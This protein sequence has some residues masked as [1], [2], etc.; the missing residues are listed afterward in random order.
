MRIGAV[1]AL[2]GVISDALVCGEGESSLGLLLFLNADVARRHTNL[3]DVIAEGLLTYNKTALGAGGKVAR[4]LVLDGAPDPA[5]GEITDK[6]YIN[7]G[8]ARGRRPDE[9]KRLFA[10]DPDNEVIIL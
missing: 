9:I 2:G 5:T 6:G 8:L 1:S 7:Q 10:A 3:R 4:A